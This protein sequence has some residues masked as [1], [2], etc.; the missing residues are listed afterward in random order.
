MKGSGQF[1]QPLKVSQRKNTVQIK[2][3][4]SAFVRLFVKTL[5][6]FKCMF[7]RFSQVHEVASKN[8]RM[9]LRLFFY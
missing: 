8:G 5:E 3:R 1:F 7:Y 4:S 6:S 2:K 9:P